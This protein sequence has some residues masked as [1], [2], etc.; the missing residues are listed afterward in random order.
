MLLATLSPQNAATKTEGVSLAKEAQKSTL[1]IILTSITGGTLS[2]AQVCD[3]VQTAGEFV[4]GPFS[5]PIRLP[6]TPF[7][8]ALRARAKLLRLARAQIKLY[9]DQLQSEGVSH[10]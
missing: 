4:R 8:R 2:Y 5:P 3:L 10:L 1:M 9:R 6:F 7:S